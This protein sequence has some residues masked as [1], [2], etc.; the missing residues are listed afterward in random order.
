MKNNFSFNT[1]G[2][3]SNSQIQV[4][5][6]GSVQEYHN[7]DYDKLIVI[8]G[9]IKSYTNEENFDNE[10]GDKSEEMKLAIEDAIN[11][12]NAKE[13]S[14]KVRLILNKM[15]NIAKNVGYG[16]ISNSIYSLLTNV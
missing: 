2:G 5:C 11:M 13:K 12:V 3:I 16:L 15:Q 14:S 7:L 1:T 4:G 6:K 8:L 9:K 10:F